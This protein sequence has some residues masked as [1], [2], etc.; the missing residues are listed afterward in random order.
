LLKLR[1]QELLLLMEIFTGFKDPKKDFTIAVGANRVLFLEVGVLRYPTVVDKR[2]PEVLADMGMIVLV[3]LFITAAGT[4][5]PTMTK[6]QVNLVFR[7]ILPDFSGDELTRLD[8]LFVV[9]NLVLIV[10]TSP[11]ASCVYAA[12][13]CLVHQGVG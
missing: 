8:R 9:E 12:N 4:G 7:R 5:I 6:H 2:H 10:N 13:F 11:E 1:L 3:K